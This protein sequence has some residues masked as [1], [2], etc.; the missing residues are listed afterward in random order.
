MTLKLVDTDETRAMWNKKFE[1]RF[2]AT[3]FADKVHFQLEVINKDTTP[4]DFTLALHTYLDVS[5]LSN[6]KIAGAFKGAKVVDRNSNGAESTETASELTISSPIDKLYKGVTE[7]HLI[8]S[9]KNKGLKIK[10]LTGFTD[11][12]VWNPHGNAAM[13]FAKF[14]CIECAA[15]STPVTVAPGAMWKAEMELEP[16][17]L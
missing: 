12:V 4:F 11:T 3:L 17:N 6:I 14:V 10:G 7:A 1:Y 2:D 15:A 5:S 8:D 9:G 13:G 16:F